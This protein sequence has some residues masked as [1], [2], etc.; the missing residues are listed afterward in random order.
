MKGLIR[1][2]V[3]GELQ[4]PP[5][6][7]RHA[8]NRPIVHARAF[9]PS[10]KATLNVSFQIKTTSASGFKLLQPGRDIFWL[11]DAP[12]DGADL[13]LLPLSDC[14]HHLTLLCYRGML[15]ITVLH[16]RRMREWL[17]ELGQPSVCSPET[18][19]QP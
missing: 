14:A 12:T 7:P 11:F 3:A 10:S 1:S 17:A 2:P 4:Q 16:G 15:Q 5:W 19:A 6:E 18:Q 9:N 8:A 13:P